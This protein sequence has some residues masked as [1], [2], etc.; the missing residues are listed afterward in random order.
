MNF[1]K[2]KYCDLWQ[3]PKMAW[4]NKYKPYEREED[5]AALSRM[6]E[7]NRVGELAKRL[8]GDSEDATV[9]NEDGT[10]DLHAMIERT[11]FFISQGTET[12]CEASF[13]KNGLYCAVD[14]LHRE[15][16]GYAIYE[17]KSA[18]HIRD[19][20]L[21]DAAYQKYVLSECGV[22]VSGVYIV[23]VNSKYLMR[24][25]LNIHEFFSV[26]EVSEL[27]AEEYEH[28]ESNLAAAEKLLDS[29]VEPNVDISELCAKGYACGYWKYCTRHLPKP[30]VFDVY[31]M[32]Y[33][34]KLAYYRSGIVSFEDLRSSGEITDSIRVRQIEHAL[35]DRGTYADKEGIKEFLSK[36]YYPLYFLDFESMQ[37]VIPV[38]EYTKP[39]SQIVFQ[40]SLHFIESEGGALKHKE[41]LA[42]S[43]P[44]PRR[45]VAERLC[46]DIPEN[47]CVLA[48]NKTFECTRIRELADLFDDL[49]ER[50]NALADGIVD[51]LEPFQ[52]GYCYNRA[53]GSSFSIKSV[54]PALYPDDP[55]LDYH[56][57]EGVHN[58]GEAMDIFPRIKDMPPLDA[59]KAR[60]D[61][62]KYCELDT[63]AMVKVWQELIRLSK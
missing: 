30:S 26:T 5:S 25:E 43:G 21:A 14:L 41:F 2:S 53:M 27:I 48:Y 34:K 52:K 40:Y 28:I 36:L 61:L 6:E 58:G 62:L 50:L 32:Q 19:R 31:K 63:L 44:D 57:L 22:K 13:D 55:S 15:N 54:L 39:Y 35:E 9:R 24:N 60:H 38:Y 1:S 29:D 8:F 45:A 49:S 18:T 7:G 20:Y 16:G 3:C 23:T 51:L 42:E 47:A 56:N 33:A 11:S 17:V 37:P 4:L 59:E 12:I 10:P 46:R